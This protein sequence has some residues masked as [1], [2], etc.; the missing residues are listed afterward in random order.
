VSSLKLK[1]VVLLTT[2]ATFALPAAG[3]L[4][5]GKQH[6]SVVLPW[7]GPEPRP[8]IFG[9]DT[10]TLDT[11]KSNMLR[12]IPAARMLGAR[13]DRFTLSPA[14]ATGDFTSIDFNVKRARSNHMGVVLSFGGIAA[15]CSIHPTPANVIACPPTT[16]SDLSRYQAYVRRVLLRYRNVVAYYESWIEPNNGARWLPAPDPA[17]YA[18]LLRAQYAVV[19]SVNLRYHRQLKLLFGSPIPSGSIRVLPFTHAVL[20]HLAGQRA[21]DGAALK[22]YR[23]SPADGP[24]VAMSDDVEGIPNPPGAAGPYPDQGCNTSPSCRITWSQELSAYEREFANHGYGQMPLWLTEFGWPG[25]AQ[26]GGPNFP[27]EATQAEYLQQACADLLKL[28][29]VQGALWFNLRDYMPGINSA[30]PQFFYHY[31]LLNYD[32]SQKPVAA[33][34]HA[35]AQANPDR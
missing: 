18:S 29:F 35:L 15:A 13:W 21:I 4:A 26:A 8:S 27:D 28:P 19:R 31:G 12:G 34:F 10:G 2:I 9:I 11:S 17:A 20:D 25:N 22:P 3:A 5:S 6:R 1:L 16:A 24:D 30:D 7:M 14:T 32:F 23:F 33:A